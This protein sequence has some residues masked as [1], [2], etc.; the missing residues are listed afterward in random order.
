MLAK[1]KW[2]P[3]PEPK[4]TRP[5]LVGWKLS[6]EKHDELIRLL[7]PFMREAQPTAFA[8]E[9]PRRYGLRSDLCLKGWPWPY[10]D[11]EAASVVHAALQRVGAKRPMWIEGQLEFCHSG[12]LRD[13]RCWVCGSPLPRHRKKFCSDSCQRIAARSPEGPCASRMIF[14]IIARTAA[15]PCRS[16]TTPARF[17]AATSAAGPPIGRW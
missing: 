16:A 8:E 15:S 13:D 1:T 12:Y 10:A 6:K 14:A 2:S 3:T 7:T 11:M 9:A 4:T 17:S 5:V